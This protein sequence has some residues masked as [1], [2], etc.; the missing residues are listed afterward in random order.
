MSDV[1]SEGSG[2]PDNIDLHPA[3]YQLDCL[4]AERVLGATVRRYEERWSGYENVVATGLDGAMY[5]IMVSPHSPLEPLWNPSTNLADAQALLQ[6][7]YTNSDYLSMTEEGTDENGYSA[8][9]WSPRPLESGVARPHDPRAAG[10]Q[11][12]EG[13]EWAEIHS[14]TGYGPSRA[15]ALCRALYKAA[16]DAGQRQVQEG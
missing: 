6:H 2:L 7:L 5:Y 15:L 1:K 3:G 8:T 12:G 14:V 10:V 11:P 13:R 9:L 16:S 4:L